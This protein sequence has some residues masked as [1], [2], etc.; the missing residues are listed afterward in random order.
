VVCALVLA[1]ESTFEHHLLQHFRG[2]VKHSIRLLVA[3]WQPFRKQGIL[4]V[5]GFRG[6]TVMWVSHEMSTTSLPEHVTTEVNHVSAE[7]FL[8][9]GQSR[10][11]A[12]AECARLACAKSI[13]SICRSFGRQQTPLSESG[14]V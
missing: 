12:A 3:Q 1:F 8:Q 7:S 9:G 2:A 4:L 5:H 10:I 14:D 13:A 11:E 6:D